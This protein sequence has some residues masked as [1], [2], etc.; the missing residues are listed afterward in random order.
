MK[1]SDDISESIFPLDVLVAILK[2]II[3]LVLILI[4]QNVFF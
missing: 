1:Y 4:E 2:T 3:K